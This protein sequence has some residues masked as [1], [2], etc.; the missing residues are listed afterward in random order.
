M[1]ELNTKAFNCSGYSTKGK[2]KYICRINGRFY[3]STFRLEEDRSTEDMGGT[4]RNRT[5]TKMY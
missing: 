4:R 3:D 1:E 5:E 2:V